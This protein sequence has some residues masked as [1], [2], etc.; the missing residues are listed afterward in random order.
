MRMTIAIAKQPVQV[1]IGWQA[2]IAALGLE[3][4]NGG[5]QVG[6]IGAGLVKASLVFADCLADFVALAA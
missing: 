3:N 2:F 6:E 1:G 4:G 5:Y